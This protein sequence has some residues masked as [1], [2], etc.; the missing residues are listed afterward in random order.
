MI[1]KSAKRC[2][3]AVAL[4]FLALGGSGC[5]WLLAGAAA[6]AGTVAYINGELV[7]TYSEPYTRVW[8]AVDG[9]V[10]GLG[11]KVESDQ[12]DNMVGEIK[13][14]RADGETVQIRAKLKG[15]KLT[16]VAVRTGLMKKADSQLIMDEID[17][18]LAKR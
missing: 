15:D 18:R 10:K 6:G 16:E 14:K 17:R 4:A 5:F 3:A 9:A 13:A 11:L 12:H 8:A 2:L 7:K 1:T